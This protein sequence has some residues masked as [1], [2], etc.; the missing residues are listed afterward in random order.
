MLTIPNNLFSRLDETSSDLHNII[1]SHKL[2]GL[3]CVPQTVDVISLTKT[4]S[5]NT[6][7]K[8]AGIT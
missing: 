1:F 2:E 8:K 6:W 5:I 4:V 7:R 3:N